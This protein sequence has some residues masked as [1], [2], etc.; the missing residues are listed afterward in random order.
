MGVL[1]DVG[2]GGGGCCLLP[3]LFEKSLTKCACGK[4]SLLE[5]SFRSMM[6]SCENVFSARSRRS[7]WYCVGRV[8]ED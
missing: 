2:D 5:E 6:Q 4:D 3:Y 1:F 8:D 7:D